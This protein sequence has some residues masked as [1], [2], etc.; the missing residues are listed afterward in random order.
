MSKKNISQEKIIQSFLS[1]AFDK[2]AGA[3]SLADIS[4]SLQIKKASLY[5]HFEKREEMYDS[6]IELCGKEMVGISFLAD[7]VLD[8]IKNGKNTPLALIKRL[9]TR[10]FNLFESD[11]LFQMYVF[12]HTEQYFNKAA[13]DV[14]QQ[15]DEKLIDDIRKVI[16]AFMAAGKLKEKSDKE[17]K[18]IAGGL[19]SIV[20]AQLDLY[21]AQRKEVIRLNPE[22]GAGTLFALPSDDVAINK[23][24]K[25][26]EAFLHAT[27]GI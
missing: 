7:K 4:E 1:S 18:E 15:V 22:S 21:I 16:Q 6:T 14:L 13:L 9:I 12:I 25:I 24:L 19:G 11:P 26:V 8:S 17:I 2:S 3:T 27:L 20:L 23:V 10:Y 5:N